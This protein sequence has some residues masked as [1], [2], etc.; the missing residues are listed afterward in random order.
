VG[1]IHAPKK[2]NPFM[3]QKRV[4]GVKNRHRGQKKTHGFPGKTGEKK[5]LKN[6][7]VPPPKR[8]EK[9]KGAPEGLLR[10]KKIRNQNETPKGKKR[11]RKVQLPLSTHRVTSGGPELPKQIA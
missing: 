10:E 3:T 11:A 1:G 7:T 6:K 4:K 2:K 8:F 5:S 9:K